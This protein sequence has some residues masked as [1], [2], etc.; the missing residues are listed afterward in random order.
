M[1]KINIVTGRGGKIIHTNQNGNTYIQLRQ[2]NA[3]VR[4]NGFVQVKNRS[5]IVKGS[6]YELEALGWNKDSEI[7]GNLVIEE[8]LT[9]F[10][11]RNPEYDFKVAGTSGVVCKLDGQPIY[12]RTIWDPYGELA[13]NKIHHNNQDEIL[14]A[15]ATSN[16]IEPNTAVE[17]AFSDENHEDFVD[18]PS[19]T[20]EEEI[21]SEDS[22]EVL[23]IDDTFEL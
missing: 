13:D 9:P 1:N 3:T 19:S 23:E 21:V 8:S 7:P 22:E 15:E 10:N 2:T 16:V 11:E 6:Q 17:D 5:F 14:A 18:D 4:D 20:I 12:R